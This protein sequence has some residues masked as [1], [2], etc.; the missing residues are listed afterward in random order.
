MEKK[1][2]KPYRRIDLIKK[3]TPKETLDKFFSSAV[4]LH[5]SFWF[6]SSL[7]CLAC[8]FSVARVASNR[9][10]TSLNRSFSASNFLSTSSRWALAAARRSR[11][12]FASSR[13]V[14]RAEDTAFT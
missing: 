7:T 4:A 13:V 11:R 12:V 5:F 10:C 1:N 2:K 6:V 14:L 9:D 8:S 3:D